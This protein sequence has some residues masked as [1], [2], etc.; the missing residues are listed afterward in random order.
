VGEIPNNHDM[1][2]LAQSLGFEHRMRSEDNVVQM[3]LALH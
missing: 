3:T 2:M 1:I